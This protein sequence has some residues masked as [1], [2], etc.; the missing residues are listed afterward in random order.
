MSNDTK[1]AG[2]VYLM[3]PIGDTPGPMIYKIGYTWK[4]RNRR[5]YARQQYAVIANVPRFSAFVDEVMVIKFPTLDDAHHTETILHKK[6]RTKMVC[7]RGKT[8]EW[9]KLSNSDIK[10]LAEEFR[11]KLIYNRLEV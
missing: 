11:D 8:S 7:N 6:F 5:A 2:L 3:A 10:W 4:L 9:F 1:V